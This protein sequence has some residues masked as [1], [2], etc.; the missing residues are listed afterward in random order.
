MPD[1]IIGGNQ[2]SSFLQ[3]PELV[4]LTR[5]QGHPSPADCFRVTTWASFK[6]STEMFVKTQLCQVTGATQQ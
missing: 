3:H 1:G 2:L 6:V 4:A 5:N